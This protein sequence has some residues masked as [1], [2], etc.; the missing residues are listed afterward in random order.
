[1]AKHTAGVLPPNHDLPDR[2]AMAMLSRLAGQA[3]LDDLSLSASD[4][5]RLAVTRLR[6]QVPE[7]ELRR[8]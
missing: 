2:R 3:R 1:M 5:I 6:D 4:V 7:K 8:A